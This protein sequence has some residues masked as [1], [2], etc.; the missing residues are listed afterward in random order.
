MDVK[1]LVK[2]NIYYEILITNMRK[3]TKSIL[4][5][6][7]WAKTTA[8]SKSCVNLKSSR[9]MA[10]RASASTDK[11][12]KKPETEISL[13]HKIRPHFFVKTFKG[14]DL[15]F[16]TKAGNLPLVR[17]KRGVMLNTQRQITFS[18]WVIIGLFWFAQLDHCFQ[19][20]SFGL[21]P[22]CLSFLRLK[23]CHQIYFP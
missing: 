14:D 1:I 10:L 5:P 11:P 2:N 21:D 15:K 13:N 7:S 8:C 16:K 18:I 12:W 22:W 4:T 6:P 17:R 9:K 19:Y 23:I 3:L 20:L